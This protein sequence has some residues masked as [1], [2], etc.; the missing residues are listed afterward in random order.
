MLMNKRLLFVLLLLLGVGQLAA[1]P[2]ELSVARK[3][4]ESFVRSNFACGSKTSDLSL[5][6]T[7]PAFY[8]FNVSSSGFIIVSS[9]DSFRP[10]VGYSDEGVFP[11]ENPS[12]EMMY[13]LDNIRQGR[14]AALR[15]AAQPNPE[16][17]EEWSALLD[18]DRAPSIQDRK[19]SFYLVKTKWNQDFPYNKFCPR[20][21]NGAYTY[22]GCV[23]TAMSQVMNYWK[24]PTHGYG[25]H[26]YTHYQFGELSADF[27]AAQYDFDMMP[28]I[29]SD[30]S[31][32]EN[33]DPIALFM[34]HC[35]IA[36]DMSYSS[37]GSGA[38]SQDVPEAVLKYFGY[39]NCCRLLS[40]DFYSL[41]EFQAI[42]KNQFD[43]GWPCYYSGQDTGGGG[44]HAFVCDG[45]DDKDMFHFNWGWGGSGDGFFAIDGLDVS[46]YA[47]NSDQAVIVNFVPT[48]VFI[49]TSKAPDGFTAVPNGDDDF[50][51][52][53]SWTNP[54]ATVEGR[55]LDTIDYIEISRDGEMIQVVENVLPGEAV[56]FV[57][58]AGKPVLVTYSIC[59]VS[60][61]VKGHKATVGG[62]N[63]GPTC[64]WT[65]RLFSDQ[66]DGWGDGSLVFMNSS[67]MKVAE[68]A[69]DKGE[70][71]FQVEIPQGWISIQWK[72]PSDSL[73]LGIEI[74]DANEEPVFSYHGPSYRM[75]QGLFYEMV[76]TCEGQI[77]E[78][79][80]SDL[81]A[82][83]V[84]NNVVLHWKGV[85]SPGYGYNIYRDG[86]FYA[87]VSDTNFT[88][89][90]VADD[91]HGYYVTSFHKEGET[92]P[93][94]TVCA[95]A[96]ID[97]YAPR[98]F[99]FEYLP[100]KKVK[101][102]WEKPENEEGLAGFE[103][104][105]M[106]PGENYKSLDVCDASQTY[107]TETKR[108]PDGCRYYYKV[109]SAYQGGAVESTP[110]HAANHPELLF[111]EVNRT[112]IPSGL[113]LEVTRENQLLLQ[114][115][116]AMLAESYNVYC[117]GELLAEGLT[118]PSFIDSPRGDALMY[119]VTGVLNGVESSPS[120]KAYYGNY[121][122]NEN[123]ES[124]AK[125]FPNP[126]NRFVTVQAE[127]I[128]EVV[129]YNLNGQQLMRRVGEGNEWN[130]D[131]SSLDAG[132]Y[133]FRIKTDLGCQ[134]QKMVLVK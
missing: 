5:V 120:H 61:G 32:E 64:P 92:E 21:D 9:D 62:V 112:H 132:V 97:E 86:V 124:F 114:W 103:I 116:T 108:L 19:N 71:E 109:V 89:A 45:Y 52:T 119:Q 17:V 8:V 65:V 29:I 85:A 128:K 101:L 68:L 87:M 76:N 100:N 57:D 134:V 43:L 133:Y 69:A 121:A 127:G 56:S 102:R 117:N 18:E 25:S 46:S 131:L 2:V 70:S 84:G 63:L 115:E 104:F 11:T 54:V 96:G 44:G 23:A 78:D 74:F 72:A 94:N 20:E 24:H 12:P 35:G 36:V 106:I 37:D 3:A 14:Q 39:S 16:I 113:T 75:P 49:H 130:M 77:G 30:M 60:H 59:A 28:N 83:I 48:D 6:M 90:D 122:V 40:R 73:E 33:I 27:S 58:K 67:N 7:T 26:S 55:P 53:L 50:S 13:Y 31:P 80:P 126:A 93:S 91:F 111:V 1:A 15:A 22:A 110:A 79:K 88:D 38:Y 47:F 118:E 41:E 129:I 99:D 4:A 51:V 42:L 105:R 123:N 66:V 125:L 98:N 81:Q 82:E 10:V 34:Y 107:Y 95:S